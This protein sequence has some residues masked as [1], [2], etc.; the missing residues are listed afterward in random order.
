MKTLYTLSQVY[1]GKVYVM[2]SDFWSHGDCLEELIVQVYLDGG[3]SVFTCAI[4]SVL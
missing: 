3:L 4:S 1:N 2:W